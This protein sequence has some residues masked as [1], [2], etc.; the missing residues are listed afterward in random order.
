MNQVP[1]LQSAAEQ[2]PLTA[3]APA[4]SAPAAVPA[5]LLTDNPDRPTPRG[6]YWEQID[7]ASKSFYPVD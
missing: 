2:L 1:T 7:P 4:P 6:R 5:S 3:S